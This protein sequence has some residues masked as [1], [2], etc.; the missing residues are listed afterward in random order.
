M[1]HGALLYKHTAV[2]SVLLVLLLRQR[3]PRSGL[4]PYGW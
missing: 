1:N 2:D 3:A 4:V